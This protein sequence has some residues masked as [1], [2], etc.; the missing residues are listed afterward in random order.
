MWSAGSSYT[1]RDMDTAE[2]IEARLRGRLRLRGV[3][4]TN[5]VAVGDRVD[6]ERDEGGETLI[7]A[8]HPR[9]NYI[10]RRST[11][12]SHESHVLAANLDQAAVVATLAAPLT[13]PEF[14]DRFLVTCEA[15]GI[16]ALIVLNKSDLTEDFP[17]AAE[18][19]RRTYAPAGYRVMEVSGVTGNGLEALQAF[20]HGK[21]TLLCG[22]SGV[23][24]S[25][26][27]K[28]LEPSAGVRIGDI[29]QYHLRGKHTTTYASMYPL[30]DGG[31]IVD[32]PGIKGFGLIDIEAGELCRYF[33]ELMR[34]GA[35]CQYYNCT[36]THE[37]GCAVQQALERGEISESRYISYLKML[38]ED[39][40]Y[41]K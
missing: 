24:K 13:K 30:R 17:Q 37:P 28:A 11:N 34:L 21:T 16:P 38:E 35:G 7:T 29:S 32:T 9:T 19:F 36:H 4:T 39:E 40:K 1:L 33:P 5:P 27:V 2:P 20:V 25:T 6:Y 8:I 3:R 23:G 31:F 14:I 41:R 10:I 26:L 18:E 15:Y 22:N 12:L